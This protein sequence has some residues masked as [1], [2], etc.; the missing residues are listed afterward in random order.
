M[1]YTEKQLKESISKDYGF[2]LNLIKNPELCGLWHIRFEVNGIKYYGCTCHA[3]A[4]PQISVDGYTTKHYFHGTPITDEWYNEF[5]KDKKIKLLKAIDRENGDWEETDITL[6][7]VEE[8]EQYINKLP[9]P[10]NYYYDVA[11]DD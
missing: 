5:I 1:N 11:Y 8:M 3:G 4:L 9:K 2:N 7:T 10:E 6:D